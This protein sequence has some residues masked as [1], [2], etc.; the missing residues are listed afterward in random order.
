MP[1]PDDIAKVSEGGAGPAGHLSD[2]FG[3]HFHY[4]RLSVTDRCNFRCAYCLP[5]GCGKE[6]LSRPLSVEEIELLAGAFASLGLWKF[7][8]TGGEPT[9]RPDL[10]E[11]VRRIAGAPGVR[12]VGLTTNGYRLAP[13]ASELRDAGLTSLNVSL[14]SLD[15]ERFERLTG[16]SHLDRVVAGVEAALAVGIPSVKV[17]VVALR[18]M[19]D[20]ELDQFLSW[21]KRSPLTVRF[22]ELM[23]TGDNQAFF[24]QHHLPAE[25]IRRKLEDRGFTRLAR[26]ESDG[27]AITYGRDDHLGSA[28]LIAPSSAGFCESCNRLRVSS[29]GALKL[30]LFGVEVPLRHLLASSA[31]RGELVRLIERSMKAKPASGL[32]E[33]GHESQTRNLASIGG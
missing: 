2:S 9:T 25:E 19:D 3:R 29:A 31:Q 33:R 27:P 22:I 28:G 13:L 17:N 6:P 14:D 12:R 1:R 5:A 32:A 10:T 4:L 24:L 8:L 16:F 18:G 11:I 30:C 20:R 7:R 26:D 21:T 23:R 15:P